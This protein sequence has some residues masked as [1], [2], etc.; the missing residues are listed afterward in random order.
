[1]PAP[2]YYRQTPEE[3]VGTFEKVTATGLAQTE[4]TPFREANIAFKRKRTDKM[5]R[6]KRAPKL[7][8]LWFS[9]VAAR[10]PS[11]VLQ[12]WGPKEKALAKHLT[13]RIGAEHITEFVKWAIENWT[14]V[15]ESSFQ[16]MRRPAPQTPTLPFLVKFV[17]LFGQ[18]KEASKDHP[19]NIEE[20]IRGLSM[21]KKLAEDCGRGY[22]K[23]ELTAEAPRR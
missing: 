11:E 9:L 3:S 1:M 10:F 12:P 23:E 16:W 6:R 4:Q 13:S 18:A 22:K 14:A 20:L 17:H 19:L 7:G 5:N 2:V 8:D 15:I 21:G